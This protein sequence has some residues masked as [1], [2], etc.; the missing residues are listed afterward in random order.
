MSQNEPERANRYG[1]GKGK[2]ETQTESSTGAD[3]KKHRG[4]KGNKSNQSA[5]QDTL[6]ERLIDI[7]ESIGIESSPARNREQQKQ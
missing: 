6:H 7:E 2:P 1:E 4:Q 5:Q 3:D